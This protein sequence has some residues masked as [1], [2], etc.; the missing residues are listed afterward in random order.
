MLTDAVAKN[1]NA[2]GK[3]K[4]LFD[5]GG[6]FLWRSSDSTTSRSRQGR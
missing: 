5:G 1:T 3:A 2:D 6:L 4:K